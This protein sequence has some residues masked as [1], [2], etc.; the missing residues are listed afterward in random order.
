[1]WPKAAA[2]LSAKRPPKG[3]TFVGRRAAAATEREE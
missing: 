2:A 1:M 3:A